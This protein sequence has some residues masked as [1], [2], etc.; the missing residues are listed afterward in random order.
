MEFKNEYLQVLQEFVPEGFQKTAHN[1]CYYL[2]TMTEKR[3]DRRFTALDVKSNGIEV[4]IYRPHYTATQFF[5]FAELKR[6]IES[7]YL[8]NFPVV[9]QQ[10]TTKLW[11]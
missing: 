3:H 5:T 6:L 1:F 10:L 4:I 2:S 11:N 8:N 7:E 9:Y